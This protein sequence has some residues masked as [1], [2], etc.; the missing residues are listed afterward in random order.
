MA[1][2]PSALLPVCLL[3]MEL[4]CLWSLA[5]NRCVGLG[6]SPSSQLLLF[7]GR[8]VDLA[9]VNAML[10]IDLGKCLAAPIHLPKGN[11]IRACI[12]L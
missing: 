5:K 3:F 11:V 10:L 4:L 7:W 6:H 2:E 1:P 9:L 8:E 12:I